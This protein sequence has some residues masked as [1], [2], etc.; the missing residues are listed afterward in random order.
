MVL[1]ILCYGD[2]TKQLILRVHTS[3]LKQLLSVKQHTSNVCVYGE[4]GGF[5]SYVY[6]QKIIIKILVLGCRVL[7]IKSE[8]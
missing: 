5:P 4:T 7:T 1:S 2:F 3:S 8:I 6:R